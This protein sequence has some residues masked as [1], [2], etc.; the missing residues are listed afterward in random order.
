MVSPFRHEGLSPPSVGALLAERPPCGLSWLQRH[1]FPQGHA[2]SQG[3]HSSDMA[4][5]EMSI[6]PG[7]LTSILDGSRATQLLS[8][9]E[10]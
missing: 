2:F 4:A 7:P 5:V 10:M 1:L 3:H 6:R 9:L 8:P